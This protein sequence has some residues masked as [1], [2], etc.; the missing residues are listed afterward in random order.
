VTVSTVLLY[1][2]RRL[3]RSRSL[4]TTKRNQRA[5]LDETR[6][7]PSRRE[8]KGHSVESDSG[9]YSLT[10]HSVFR[11]SEY[12]EYSEYSK[13]SECTVSVE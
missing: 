5:R 11:V 12:S 13:Y 7:L 4:L 9:D 1:Q 3:A 8:E 10:I 6:A 2:E